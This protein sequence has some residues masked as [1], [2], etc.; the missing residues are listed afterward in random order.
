MSDI[1]PGDE[2]GKERFIWRMHQPS[3]TRK[4]Q[5]FPAK[6]KLSIT[7]GRNSPDP[8]QAFALAMSQSS[9]VPD[10]PFIGT[11]MRVKIKEQSLLRRRKPSVS[12]LG[13][14]TTVQEIA[15]DS[16]ESFL[17]SN[18]EQ[19][20]NN[21][22]TIPRRPPLHERS[23]SAPGYHSWQRNMSGDTKVG[24]VL[25][26]SV[27]TNS[28]DAAANKQES[29]G[30]HRRS[31]SGSPKGLLSPKSLAPL[32]IPSSTGPI[33]QR[34]VTKKQSSITVDSPAD[35]PPNVPPKSARM[36]EDKFSPQNRTPFTPISSSTYTPLSSTAANPSLSST[37]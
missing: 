28:V 19:A 15:M 27:E 30:L 25:D 20:L 4:Y 35:M 2:K 11:T 3:E 18:Y 32:V 24:P 1:S 13:L 36:L 26:E 14:M 29:I 23:A 37:A 7:P 6:D 16:R 17:V 5:L 21:A 33:P 10:R 9:T 22:A 8:E 34:I 31:R 12:D